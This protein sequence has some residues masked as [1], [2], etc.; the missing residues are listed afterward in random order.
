M[1]QTGNDLDAL[2]R[3]LLSGWSATMRML[4]RRVRSA[5]PEPALPRAQVELLRQV[6]AEPGIRVGDAARSLRLAPNTVSTLAHELE[7][8]GLL[9]C[10][11]DTGD[12]RAVHL[13]LTAAAHERL[14]RW[15]DERVQT[16]ARA[17]GGLSSADLRVLEQAPVGLRAV[18]DRLEEDEA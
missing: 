17:L 15:R 2:A 4:R 8:D 13:N 18:I 9:E 5:M 16:L 11:P 3:D 1:A 10:G 12:G 14:G 7:R 6:E